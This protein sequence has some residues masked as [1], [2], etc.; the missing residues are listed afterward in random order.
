MT[1][2]LK[3]FLL[4]PI[5]ENQKPINEYIELKENWFI[6]WTTFTN[7]NYVK[8]FFSIYFFWFLL[9]FIFNFD[10]TQMNLLCLNWL[11][12]MFLQ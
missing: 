8:K 4:C 7:S 11:N 12:M 2:T 5:P 1:S 9:V 3:L 6:N 10:L